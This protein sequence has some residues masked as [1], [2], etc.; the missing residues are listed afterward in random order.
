MNRLFILLVSVFLLVIEGF[1]EDSLKNVRVGYFEKE[2]YQEGSEGT[3]LYGYAYEYYQRVAQYTGWRYEY[4]FG[5]R[6][7]IYQKFLRGEVD[8][9]VVSPILRN[10][11]V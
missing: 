11:I 9:M 4:V 3:S 6:E 7:E 2:N 1:C 10:W 5:S 8:L